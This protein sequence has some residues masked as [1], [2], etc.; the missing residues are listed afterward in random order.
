MRILV[1]FLSWEGFV[2]E[3]IISTL[4][5]KGV[6]FTYYYFRSHDGIE[7]DLLLEAG[8][9]LIAIEIKLSSDPQ[10]DD[11]RHLNRYAEI[12]EAT[13]QVLICRT[14]NAIE[15][16]NKCYSNLEHALSYLEKVL[17]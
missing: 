10:L 13:H 5:Q 3:Q 14:N 6:M 7:I 8:A 1:I 17:G 16:A 4:G 11:I 9:K 15:A 12:I 2:I